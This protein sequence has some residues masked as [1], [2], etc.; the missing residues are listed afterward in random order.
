M[1]RGLIAATLLIAAGGWTQTQGQTGGVTLSPSNPNG[2]FNLPNATVGNPSYPQ[3]L[4]ASPTNAT[5]TWQITNGSLPP[6]L[7]LNTSATTATIGFFSPGNGPTTPGPYTFT[8]KAT[9]NVA[10]TANQP[11]ASQQYTI[12]VTG[13]ACS[14]LTINQTTLP[15][16]I[17]NSNYS[18][19][20]TASGGVGNYQW[21]LSPTNVQGLSIGQN[22]GT[23]TGTPPGPPGSYQ[24]T[25][26]VT[27]SQQNCGQKQFTLNVSS[28]SQGQITISP[29]TLPNGTLNQVYSQTLFATPPTS[30]FNPT[31]TWSLY[32][33]S[34]PPGFLLNPSSDTLSATISG[35]P[36]NVGTYTFTVYVSSSNSQLSG[37]QQYTI[38]VTGSTLTIVQTTLPDAVQNTPYNFTLTANGGVPPYTWS[39]VNTSNQS[40]QGLSIDS[41]TGTITGSPPT[42][43]ISFTLTVLV[44]DSANTSVQRSYTLFVATQLRILNTSLANGSIGTPYSQTL[45]PGGGQP[46]YQWSVTGTLP[47]GLIFDKPTATISGTPTTNGT[48]PI[49]VQ[50]SDVGNRTATASFAITIGPGLTI[51]TT[52][53]PDAAVGVAY[54]QTLT[55]TGGA[56]P[57]SWLITSG[58]LPAGLTLATA[59][60]VIS[61][62]P[63][64]VGTLTFTVQVTDAANVS[65]QATFT[66]NIVSGLSIATTSLPDAMTGVPYS[67]ALATSGGQGTLTW[68]V[69]P[70]PP[71]PGLLL[72]TATGAITGTPNAA[73]TFSFT[74]T[75]TDASK[76][77]AQAS[78][79]I[80]VT[81]PPT[82][83][84]GNLTATAGLPFS[85]T[86][87]GSGGTPPY[88]FSISGLPAGLL[89]DAATGTISGTPTTPGS[90]N[91]VVGITD[92][93]GQTATKTI[94]MTVNPPPAVTIS[95]VPSTAPS[96]T[97]QPLTVSTGAPL[98]APLDGTLTLTFVPA[99]GHDDAMIVL[100]TGGRNLTFTIPAGST[101]A[102][103][104]FGCLPNVVRTG[105]TAGRITL[106]AH[107]NNG[108]PDTTTNIDINP[109]KPV[110]TAVAFQQ[111][112]SGFTISVTG[113][114][115]TAELVSATFDFVP[116]SNNSFATSHFVVSLTSAAA[117]WFQ[118]AASIATGGSF[119]ATF[120]F[121]V[122]GNAQAV[123]SY[124]VTVTSAQGDSN[125]FTGNP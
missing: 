29:T 88:K 50:L 119:T 67:Q 108:G 23:I 49:T 72:N 101:Q 90:S 79:T 46:P 83:S 91:I 25:V 8:V 89:F 121:T 82:I 52:T 31:L 22:T 47:P 95:G 24:F 57:L 99:S 104:P 18:T 93:R 36:T 55:A 16:A 122:Q 4:T 113:F 87:A 11:S 40:T 103:L 78:F 62:T 84:T 21:S 75:V 64:N 44:T 54:S 96:N 68:S 115:N 45:T 9:Q 107:L 125:T 116:A 70:N 106:T 30:T 13:P 26:S 77:T 76:Q 1:R 63:T 94:T 19:T 38:V 33:G 117:A 120:P 110:I 15:T 43:G 111:Q 109:A 2:T 12:T 6:G 81:G 65:K 98:A 66:I 42:A 80:L 118:N 58:T 27:D 74:V 48:Y 3:T 102:V 56:A 123:V 60:G 10:G 124:K 14:G 53:L 39:F 92:S 5:Y 61:G 51:T 85:V 114:S 112:T 20:L 69:S 17:Q 41:K 105:T 97:Q 28:T 7:M 73:G 71:V 34:L 35:T 32:S 37:S 86:L 100:C 59:T